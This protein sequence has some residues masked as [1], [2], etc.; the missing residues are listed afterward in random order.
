MPLA[1]SRTDGVTA[2]LLYA[3]TNSLSGA[4]ISTTGST[5]EVDGVSAGTSSIRRFPPELTTVPDIRD[6]ET[7]INGKG[8]INRDD[9]GQL[10]GAEIE[11]ARQL[12]SWF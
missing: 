8:M 5:L 12:S 4:S 10:S 3:A 1:L 11:E 2:K 9:N 7:H 6:Y